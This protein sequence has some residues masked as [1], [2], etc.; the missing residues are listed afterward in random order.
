MRRNEWQSVQLSRPRFSSSV[1]G[2][3]AIH[4]ALVNCSDV[5]GAGVSLRSA[6]V[7]PAGRQVECPAAVERISG[8]P[9]CQLIA[10]R[11]QT[12]GGECVFTLG[13]ADH[14]H[15]DR[16]ADQLCADQDAFHGALA[17]GGDLSDKR[18]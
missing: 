14:R 1:P 11:R 9:D 15:G 4:S 13:V 6:R 8:G 5:T 2:A 10:A 7:G 12:I 17:L 3:L 16:R 18:G